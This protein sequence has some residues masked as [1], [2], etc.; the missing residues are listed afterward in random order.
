[1]PAVDRHEVDLQVRG[2]RRVHA[3]A[4]GPIVAR[5]LFAPEHERRTRLDVEAAA[6]RHAAVGEAT[7]AG[8]HDDAPVTAGRQETG[9][10]GGVGGGCAVRRDTDG[11][12]GRQNEER[13][14]RAFDSPHSIVPLPQLVYANESIDNAAVEQVL[15]LAPGLWIWRLSYAD[16]H[17]GAGWP[18]VVTSTCVAT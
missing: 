4:D 5:S 6:N 11:Q 15:D 12:R 18:E 14:E 7:R 3:S 17:Q 10:G 8:G 16:W 1:D 13:A 9:A 2:A